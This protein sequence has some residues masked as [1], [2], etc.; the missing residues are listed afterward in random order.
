MKTISI[1]LLIIGLIPSANCARYRFNRETYPLHGNSFIASSIY[2]PDTLFPKYL[3]NNCTE[4]KGIE[5]AANNNILKLASNGNEKYIIIFKNLVLPADEYIP[6]CYQ[7]YSAI[8]LIN[9]KPNIKKSIISLESCEIPNDI[10]IPN[11]IQIINDSIIIKANE[12]S[13]EYEGKC[14]R[15][16]TV[17]KYLI[18]IDSAFSYTNYLENVNKCENLSK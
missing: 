6:C 10:W 11:E 7:Q 8:N 18:K 15:I 2:I 13:V 17:F 1:L 3:D 5:N 12:Y 9:K 16:D 14:E 4:I